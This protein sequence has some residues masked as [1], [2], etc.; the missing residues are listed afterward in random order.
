MGRREKRGFS[1]VG[2]GGGMACHGMRG[3]EGGSCMPI[4]KSYGVESKEMTGEPTDTV[5]MRVANLSFN[6]C[7]ISHLP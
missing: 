5:D 3:R 7:I 4:E 6:R 1:R 2:G